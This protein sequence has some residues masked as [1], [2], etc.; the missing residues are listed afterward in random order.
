MRRASPRGYGTNQ[1]CPPPVG[2]SAATTSNAAPLG[3]H[4]N[5]YTMGHRVDVKGV[6]EESMATKTSDWLP[7]PNLPLKAARAIVFPSGDQEGLPSPIGNRR[8]VSTFS[9]V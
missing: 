3:S 9:F 7:G 8:R 4:A 5:S 2:P 6:S 1:T